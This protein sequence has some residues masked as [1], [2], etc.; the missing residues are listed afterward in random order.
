[1]EYSQPTT[2]IA[3]WKVRVKRDVEPKKTHSVETGPCI[4]KLP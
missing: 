3:N 2:L 1:V 4:P